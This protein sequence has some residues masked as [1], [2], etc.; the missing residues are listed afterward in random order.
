[1]NH[2]SH[3]CTSKVTGKVYCSQVL[4]LTANMWRTT[5]K[6][7]TILCLRPVRVCTALNTLLKCRAPF[8]VCGIGMVNVCNTR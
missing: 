7:M 6:K 1:M 8:V 2:F 4:G 5:D 3:V